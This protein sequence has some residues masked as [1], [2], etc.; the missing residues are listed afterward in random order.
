VSVFAKL[1]V[2][3]CQN[4]AAAL[5]ITVCFSVDPVPR[6][7]F[8]GVRTRALQGCQNKGS[9]ST[10]AQVWCLHI[11]LCLGKRLNSLKMQQGT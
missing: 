8:K 4:L 11:S 7:P 3:C 5:Y 6:R 1:Q 10:V 9:S 2:H